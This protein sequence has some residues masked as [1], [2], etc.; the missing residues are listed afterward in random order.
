MYGTLQDELVQT[1]SEIREA[2]L[3]KSELPITTPQGATS[4]S[5]A[6]ESCS[7]SAATTTSASPTTRRSS[8]PRTTRSTAGA[9]GWPRCA[10]SAAPRRSTASSR[11]AWQR[12]S[13]PTTRSSSAPAST[14]TAASSRRCSARRTPSS[15][16]SSTRLDH[17]RDPALQGAAAAPRATATWTS[18][19][20]GSRSAGARRRLIATDGVFSMDGYLARLDRICELA[21]RHDALVM[22][23]DS[24]AVG[25]VG[26]GGRGT[27]EHGV[28][29][30]VD[31]LTGTLGKAI[32]GERRLRLRPPRDHRAAPPARPALSLLEQPGAAGRRR[33]PAGAR[34]DRRL[35]RAARQLR[36]NTA[37]FRS[38]MTELGFE[39]LPASTR[40][41]RS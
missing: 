7:P 13:A 20:R 8:R 41:S 12:S 1:L 22:V 10:S 4:T 34:A 24:H 21:E 9:T 23:D 37:R 38:G 26:P 40:S 15:P 35:R 28:V 6:G 27:P 16:T 25:V 19:R 17:R 39:I 29:E 3:Y 31:I 11:S 30:R 18:S 14:P 5:R 36:E 33:Q 2:G 32:G